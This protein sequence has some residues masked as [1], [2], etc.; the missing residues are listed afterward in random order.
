MWRRPQ[1]EDVLA[2][3]TLGEQTDDIAMEDR[4]VRQIDDESARAKCEKAG[5][6][7]CK[8]GYGAIIEL[9]VEPNRD[10]PTVVEALEF[11]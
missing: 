6:R 5:Q 8:L 4:N 7:C 10:V 9:A 2:G 11:E 1:H 3:P